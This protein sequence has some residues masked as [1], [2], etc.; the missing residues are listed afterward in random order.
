MK[1]KSPQKSKK[2]HHVPV[3]AE[4]VLEFLENYQRMILGEN[5]KTKAISVRV[6]KNVL[7]MFKFMAKSRNLEYQRVLVGLM[8]KW[9]SGSISV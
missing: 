2:A 7:K 5:N 8:R 6:P 4:Q 9:L 1:K 3:E